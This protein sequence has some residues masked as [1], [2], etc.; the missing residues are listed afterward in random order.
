[1]AMSDEEIAKAASGSP[2]E[3]KAALAKAAETKDEPVEKKEPEAAPEVKAEVAP[4]APAPAEIETEEK[5]SEPVAETEKVETPAETPE[6]KAAREHKEKS[7][8]GRK[9]KEQEEARIKTLEQEIADLKAK[10]SAPP[11]K[12]EIP[13]PDDDALLTRKEVKAEF[14]RIQRE[15]EAERV[16][17]EKKRKYSYEDVY[18]K[19]LDGLKE[20]ETDE[21][22]YEE[23]HA[24]ITN[25][26]SEFNVQHSWEAHKDAAKNYKAAREKILKSK[27][28]PKENPLKGNPPAIPLGVA[29][30]SKVEAQKKPEVKLSPQAAAFVKKVGMTQKEV[31]EALK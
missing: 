7:S 16:E 3:F 17:Q 28:K 10:V 5:V 2:D 15:Q 12:V 13:P 21:E 31:E 9:R 18:L 19:T 26:D 27:P 23:V 25:P 29:S 1:M 24:E 11:P 6:E 8:A 20:L 30:G 14:E 22:L 4:E